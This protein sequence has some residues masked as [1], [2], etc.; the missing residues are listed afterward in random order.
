MKVTT[1]RKLKEGFKWCKENGKNEMFTFIYLQG[2]VG[3]D[4][5]CVSKFFE[6]LRLTGGL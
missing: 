4:E 5:K 2:Y 3:V 6:K 1:K